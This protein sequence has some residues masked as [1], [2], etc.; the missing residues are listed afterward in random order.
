MLSNCHTSDIA[1]N[2]RGAGMAAGSPSGAPASTQRTMVSISSSLSEMSFLKSWIPT[3]LSICQG[4]MIRFETLCLIN[5]ANRLTCS[6]VSSG[7]GPIE[8]GR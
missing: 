1:S 8:P 6:Y 5:G 7:I 2:F 4:G 3:V